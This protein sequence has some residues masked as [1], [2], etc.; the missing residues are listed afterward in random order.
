MLVIQGTKDKHIY[1]EKMEQFI[2]TTFG[3]VAEY[4]RLDGAGHSPFY[5]L[6]ETVN[7]LILDFV[8]RVSR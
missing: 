1:H 6:P 2:R 5:E 4:H 7:R 8:E 3:D